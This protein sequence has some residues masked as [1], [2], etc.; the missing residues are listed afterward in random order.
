M[1]DA[2]RFDAGSD[3]CSRALGLDL[4]AFLFFTSCAFP[5]DLRRNWGDRKFGAGHTRNLV[6]YAV[7]LLLKR[8]VDHSDSEFRL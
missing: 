5:A 7:R 3:G 8:I 4:S 2:G 1:H 6:G